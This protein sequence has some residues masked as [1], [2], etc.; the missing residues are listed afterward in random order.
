[1]EGLFKAGRIL[2]A[3]AIAGF[4]V[5]CLLFATGA[6][7]PLPGPPWTQH[8]VF[9]A[10]LAGAGLL[11]AA[12]CLALLWQP[13][14]AAGVLAAGILLRALILYLPKLLA[15]LR[16]PGPW[17]TSFELL[18]IG[19]AALVLASIF[20]PPDSSFRSSLLGNTGRIL[21][22]ASL[23]VF[24]VQHWMYARFVSM[25]VPAWIPFR[26]FWAYA[27]GLAFF[28]AAASLLVRRFVQPVCTLLAAM[29]FLWVL[30]LHAP[31]VAASPH[32]GEEW[33]S[34]LVAL[35]VGAAS[36]ILAETRF[37]SDSAA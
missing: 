35:A 23:I 11:L 10:A 17:T 24:G 8:N 18:A 13:R 2:F 32:S 6:R 20:A 28:G 22:A 15:H 27:T 5:Q 26:L 14:V 21:F 29:F 9:L 25:L 31:R 37:R 19:A 7:W 30:I 16:D 4:G 3:V 1:M 33:T 34:F 36:L 12:L